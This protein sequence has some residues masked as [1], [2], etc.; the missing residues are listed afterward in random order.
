MARRLVLGKVAA[1]LT[2]ENTFLKSATLFASTLA[3]VFGTRTAKNA[4][5]LEAA[6]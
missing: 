4:A 6:S 1:A 2:L 3:A 5:R